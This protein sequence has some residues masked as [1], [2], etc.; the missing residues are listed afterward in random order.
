VIT[1]GFNSDDLVGISL[2]KFVV[3]CYSMSWLA[4]QRKSHR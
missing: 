1:Q 2:A 4:S 3:I